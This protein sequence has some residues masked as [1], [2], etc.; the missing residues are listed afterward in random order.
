MTALVIDGREIA[1][2]RMTPTRIVEALDEIEDRDPCLDLR[3]EAMSLK[4]L[5]FE[6]GEEALTHG[7]VVGVSDRAH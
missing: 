5:A 6:R 1:E 2:R 3:L 7:V 4:K